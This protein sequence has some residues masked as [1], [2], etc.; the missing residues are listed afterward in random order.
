MESLLRSFSTLSTSGQS[1]TSRVELL[2]FMK[3]DSKQFL[4]TGCSEHQY[5]QFH[6]FNQLIIQ[7]VNFSP[8][9]YSERVCGLITF[10]TSK[11]DDFNDPDLHT[12]LLASYQFY[13]S[14]ISLLLIEEE[15]ERETTYNYYADPEPV[16]P[17]KAFWFE[18]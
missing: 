2:Y 8:D 13:D 4:K 1:S 5:A 12:R 18:S 15:I 3:Q 6:N 14:I 10:I 7:S 9:I 17:N 16:S 11:M